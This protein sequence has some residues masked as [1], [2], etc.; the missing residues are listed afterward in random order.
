MDTLETPSSRAI[1]LLNG[2]D[3]RDVDYATIPYAPA[4]LHLTIRDENM[5]YSEEEWMS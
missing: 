3:I 5:L 2:Y 4:A 1:G